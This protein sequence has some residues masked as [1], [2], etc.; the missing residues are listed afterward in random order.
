MGGLIPGFITYELVFDE[1]FGLEALGLMAFGLIFV[2]VGILMLFYPKPRVFDK[3]VGWFWAGSKN[4]T[5]EQEFLTLEKSARLN[6]IAAIQ[7][8]AERLS[9]KN[10]SY[11]SWEINLVSHDAKR[12]NVMDHGNHKSIKA[13]AQMLSNFLNVP[14]WEKA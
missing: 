12:L 5:D 11:T 4:L 6:D 13:D 7:I 1:G 14:V 3:Q 10:S 9:G 2:G 8:V